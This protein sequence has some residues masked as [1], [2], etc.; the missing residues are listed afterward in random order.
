M[1][2]LILTA[3]GTAFG[4]PIGGALGALI[5]QQVDA[6]VFAPPS[7]KGPRLKDLS[8]QSSSYG[9]AI[10]RHYGRMRAAGSVIWATEL[11]ETREKSGGGKGRPKVVTYSYS[12]SFA[13]ALASRPILGVG[14]IWADG[15]LL[16]GAED[17][18]KAAGALR[19]HRGFGDQA[20]DPL[21]MAAEGAGQA[22]AFRHI[23]YA[24]LEDL[25]LA[26]FGN[27]IP[28][29]TFEVIAD[30]GAVSLTSLLGDA[31]P[32]A[33]ITP[34]VGEV[35][36]FGIDGGTAGDL[37]ESLT[38]LYPLACT[39]EAGMVRI[40]HAE[41]TD[42]VAPALPEPVPARSEDEP[43]GPSGFA[44]QRERQALRREAAVRYYD[45]ARDY[46]PGIQRGRGR[47]QPGPALSIDFPA[48]LDAAAARALADAVSRRSGEPRETATY[49]IA[50]IDA[51]YSPGCEVRIAGDPAR[52]LVEGW[53]WRSDGVELGL[54]MLPVTTGATGGLSDPGRANLPADLPA[55]ATRLAALELPWDGIGTGTA[56]ALF[57]AVSSAGAGWSGAA[58]FAQVPGGGLVALGPSGRQRAT[59]GRTIG[60]LAPA[61][62]HLLDRINTLEVELAGPDLILTEAS[63]AQLAMG[64]NRAVVGAELIQ[65]ARAEPRGAGVWRLT[66]LLRGRGGTEL[67]IFSHEAGDAFALIDED[68]V[69]LD[70]ALVGDAALVQI[71]ALGLI[72]PAPVLA[73]IL[74]AGATRRPLSPVHGEL[75][76]AADGALRLGWTRRA[77]GAL[78][79]PDAVE[80]PLNEAAEAYR[81]VLGDPASPVAQ[82]ETAEPRLDISATLAAQLRDAAPGAWFAVRQRG[83]HGLS[84][85]LGLGPLVVMAA[86]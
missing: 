66:D 57:A 73:P 9:A 22:P 60:V 11:S 21:I 29:L 56:P 63:L 5:G 1:A 14:R 30:D 77:R 48:A 20:P 65:F 36:G 54:R 72:D 13:V 85:P 52:W 16:R 49:K 37:I 31:V 41:R 70:P 23:A 74:L 8:V 6:A 42:R 33:R 7:R 83:D 32:G 62:P 59:I 28:S 10:P 76:V 24:V 35:A 27:R 18:L 43:G 2:T 71:A 78:L 17:D 68:L 64:A 46:Q 12:S 80:T 25:A 40:A 55:S 34:L 50:E 53:E 47:S 86:N 81:I 19:V 82:W 15:N 84:E 39:V 67:G 51:R 79:W 44:R 69:A 3:V 75:I 38:A 61:P 58:L 4:G 45:T 26:E